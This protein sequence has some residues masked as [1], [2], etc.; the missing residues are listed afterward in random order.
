ME[1]LLYLKEHEVADRLCL[2]V[3][4]LRKWR[5]TGGGPEYAKFGRAVR[6]PAQSLEE[7]AEDALRR[8][9]ADPGPMPERR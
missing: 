6:Y 5:L 3:R 4:T 2:S 8:S 9:T 1:T 7:F